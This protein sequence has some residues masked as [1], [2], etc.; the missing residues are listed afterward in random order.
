MR[1]DSPGC[2]LDPVSATVAPGALSALLLWIVCTGNVL[3][4]GSATSDCLP[5][6][7]GDVLAPELPLG[8]PL[9]LPPGLAPGLAPGASMLALSLWLVQDVGNMLGPMSV[10]SAIAGAASNSAPTRSRSVNL[11]L[12]FNSLPSFFDTHATH[13]LAEP[14]MLYC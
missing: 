12:S 9:G 4:L 13:L 5:W 11:L 14:I 1:M 3:A 10:M 7:A 8:L 6:I 2:Q